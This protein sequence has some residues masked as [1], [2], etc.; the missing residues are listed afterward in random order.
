MTKNFGIRAE[1]E[2]FKAVDNISLLSVGVAYK[3]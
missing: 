2:Q 1:W 3:F